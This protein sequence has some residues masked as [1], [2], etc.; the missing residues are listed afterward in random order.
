MS[1][2]FDFHVTQIAFLYNQ[3]IKNPN[4]PTYFTNRALCYIKLKRFEA[5]CEDCRRG[6]DMDNNLIKGHFF[7]GLSL[8]ELECFDEAI[9]HLQRGIFSIHRVVLKIKIIDFFS[10]RLRQGTEIE[11]WR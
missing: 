8:M 2:I 3:Q 9:K 11:L 7:L 4:N 6:L 5:A 1:I 10:S